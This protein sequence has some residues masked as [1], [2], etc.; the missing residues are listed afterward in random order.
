VGRTV[1][2]DDELVVEPDDDVEQQI[3]E[4]GQ[5]HGGLR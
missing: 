2:A 1:V 3:A 5:A 4:R